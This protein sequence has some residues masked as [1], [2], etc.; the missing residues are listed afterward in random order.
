MDSNNAYEFKVAY[1][2]TTGSGRAAQSAI[3][4]GGVTLKHGNSVPATLILLIKCICSCN[5][6]VM[7]CTDAN[8]KLTFV[9]ILQVSSLSRL[10][11][12]RF[13]GSDIYV[14][15]ETR[16]FCKF[17]IAVHRYTVLFRTF[18]IFSNC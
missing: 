14:R 7:S 16:H 15:F 8:T 1:V 11:F 9:Q 5:N 17:C 13:Y 12:Y 4:T 6:G 10:A 3:N 18:E 2:Y